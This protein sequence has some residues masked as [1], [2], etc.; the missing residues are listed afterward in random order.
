M[1]LQEINERLSSYSVFDLINEE[2]RLDEEALQE[3]ELNADGSVEWEA[4]T[5][6]EKEKFSKDK[7][8]YQH[9]ETSTGAKMKQLA[10]TYPIPG[11]FIKFPDA[12]GASATGIIIAMDVD[13]GVVTVIDKDKKQLGTFNIKDLKIDVK[14]K[15]SNTKYQTVYSLFKIDQKFAPEDKPVKR[16][17][18]NG[19]A[20]GET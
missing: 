18:F 1:L 4:P 16:F 7:I 17:I 2:Y 11:D 10:A 8:V 13:K 3:I 5:A 6:A 14:Q 19:A 15:A 20:R 9:G 12:D